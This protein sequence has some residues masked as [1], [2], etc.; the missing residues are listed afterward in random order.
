MSRVAEIQTAIEQLSPQ[1]KQQLREWLLSAPDSMTRSGQERQQ[2]HRRARLYRRLRV[3]LTAL[4]LVA[5]VYLT[6]SLFNRPGSASSP[7]PEVSDDSPPV[8]FK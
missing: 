7:S 2:R 3:L 8:Q 4:F 5:L 1:E 6:V